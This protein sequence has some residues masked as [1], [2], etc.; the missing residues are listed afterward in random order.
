MLGDAPL[1][2]GIVLSTEQLQGSQLT[3]PLGMLVQRRFK[4]GKRG[5]QFRTS[6][7][8]CLGT[9]LTDAIF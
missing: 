2:R 3:E 7:D 6:G 4:V 9:Q 8:E 1:G 5:L